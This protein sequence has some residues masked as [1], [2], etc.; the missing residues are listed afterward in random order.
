MEI[1]IDCKVVHGCLTTNMGQAAKEYMMMLHDSNDSSLYLRAFRYEGQA[2]VG[3]FISC[4]C[5]QKGNM[6]LNHSNNTKQ[7]FRSLNSIRPVL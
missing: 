6:M 5:A 4:F 1:V 3:Q 2:Q 7:C